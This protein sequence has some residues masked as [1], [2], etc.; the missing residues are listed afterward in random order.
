MKYLKTYEQI[1]D[2]NSI[3][4][5]GDFVIIDKNKLKKKNLSLNTINYINSL[6]PTQII[7]IDNKSYKNQTYYYFNFKNW[8]RFFVK[9]DAIIRKATPEE[10]EEYKR[11]QQIEKFNI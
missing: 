4:Q 11:N 5:E 6:N 7:H 3:Y 2:G 9:I 1:N 8:N 10:I